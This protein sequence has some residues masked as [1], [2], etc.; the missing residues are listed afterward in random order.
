MVNLLCPLSIGTIASVNKEDLQAVEK[1]LTWSNMTTENDGVYGINTDGSPMPYS[2]AKITSETLSGVA[3]VMYG[4]PLQISNIL[5]NNVDWGYYYYDW[6]SDYSEWVAIDGISYRDYTGGGVT[7]NNG[8]LPQSSGSYFDIPH[9]TE[10][11]DLWPNT[12]NTALAD[13]S[14]WKYTEALITKQRSSYLGGAI[15]TYRN[16][17]VYKDWLIPTCGQLAYV[18]LNINEINTLFTKCSV[19]TQLKTSNRYWSSSQS[20]EGQAWIVNFAN[21]SVNTTVYNAWLPALLLRDLR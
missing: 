16:N 4:R 17:S 20:H 15:S 5:L 6:E 1:I 21:G 10:S 18:Y 7:G 11:Y 13:T 12:T 8:F 9:I 14:G 3:I 19:N 2:E